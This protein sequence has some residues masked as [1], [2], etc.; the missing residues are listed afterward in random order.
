MLKGCRP[1]ASRGSAGR[2]GSTSQQSQRVAGP[3]AGLP[4]L[5]GGH[6]EQYMLVAQHALVEVESFQGLDE[7]QRRCPCCD[8][9]LKAIPGVVEENTYI[10]IV[11]EKYVRVK[12]CDA[13][14]GP[15]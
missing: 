8:G 11:R 9:E 1:S 3:T 14:G 2:T 5:R 7:D 13:E 10:T 4:F 15:S 12:A 6:V